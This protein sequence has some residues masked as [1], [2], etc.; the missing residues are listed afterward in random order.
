MK[1]LRPTQIVAAVLLFAVSVI[2]TS[3]FAL[4][5]NVELDVVYYVGADVVGAQIYNAC[6]GH[7]NYSWGQFSG[8]LMLKKYIDCDAGTAQCYWYSWT[9]S[10]W[11]LIRSGSCSPS[12]NYERPPRERI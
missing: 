10:G 1:R 12:G 2:P 9:G 5:E 8:D 4:P 3:S 7:M 6:L 11:Q